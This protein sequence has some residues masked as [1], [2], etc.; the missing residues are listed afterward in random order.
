MYTLFL[1]FWKISFG[2]DGESGWVAGAHRR[3]N[4]HHHGEEEEG[5]WKKCIKI[6]ILF[7]PCAHGRQVE[8]RSRKWTE[9]NK[10]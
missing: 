10:I 9:E 4:F 2:H 6:Y 3:K 7:L 8:S 1:I 5:E